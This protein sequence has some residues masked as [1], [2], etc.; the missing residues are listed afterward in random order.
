[1]LY[2]AN[3]ALEAELIMATVGRAAMA[4]GSTAHPL[5]VLLGDH[6]LQEAMAAV[7]DTLILHRECV[8][9]RVCVC[10]RERACMCACE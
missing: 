5:T 1:M 6:F 9:V 3:R 2:P 7:H 10:V 4:T 8:C